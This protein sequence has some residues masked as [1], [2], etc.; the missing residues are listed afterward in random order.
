MSISN[1]PLNQ[2]VMDR[3]YVER[4]W[5]DWFT[6]V[7]DAVE[8]TPNP[9]TG[10]F[11]VGSGYRYAVDTTAGDVTVTL[12]SIALATDKGFSI[13][14]TDSSANTVIITADGSD[15]ILGDTTL[16]ITTQYDAADIYPNKNDNV[17]YAE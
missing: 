9:Q 17:W 11:T 7:T 1:P 5:A 2:P 14:K 15:T 12:P 8:D 10:D 4:T 6:R 13:T 16:I 3:E